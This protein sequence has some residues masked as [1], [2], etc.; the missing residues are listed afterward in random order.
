MSHGSSSHLRNQTIGRAES[1]CGGYK[2]PI[3][4]LRLGNLQTHAAPLVGQDPGQGLFCPLVHLGLPDNVLV[5]CLKLSSAALL[6]VLVQVLGQF[7]YLWSPQA[8]S[9]MLHEMGHSTVEAQPVWPFAC[10]QLPGRS[11]HLLYHP[12]AT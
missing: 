11:T 3:P 2:P 12:G 8:S 1:R 5:H 6:E 9:Q 10:D 7:W 4:Q